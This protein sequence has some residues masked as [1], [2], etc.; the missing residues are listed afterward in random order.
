ML[1]NKALIVSLKISQ[2]GARKF[3]RNATTTVESSFATSGKVGNY[4]KKLLPG[5]KELEDI[6]RLSNNLRTFFHEQSLPWLSDGSRILSSKNYL[7]FTA[8]FRVKKQ[9][10]EQAVSQFLLQYPVL[11]ERSKILLG[12]LFKET[13]YPSEQYLKKAF[14]CKI[15]FMPVPNIDDFR[16]QILDEEKEVFLSKMKDYFKE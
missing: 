13:D 4:T 12:S 6:Q 1:A 15:A 16:V 7:D 9:E 2:W 11:R 3:D 10:F 5:A 8:Q 14:A